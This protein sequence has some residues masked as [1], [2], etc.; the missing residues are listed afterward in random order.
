MQTE[1][2]LNLIQSM[3]KAEKRF[4]RRFADMS[5]GTQSERYLALFSAMETLEEDEPEEL[6]ALVGDASLKSNLP[7]YRNRLQSL[8]LRSL[9]TLYAG[10]SAGSEIRQLLEEIEILYER[11]LFAACGKR[12]EKALSIATSHEQESLLMEIHAWRRKLTNQLP[13]S[14]QDEALRDLR[15]DEITAVARLEKEREMAHHHERQR[16]R[17]RLRLVERG[18]EIH[19]VELPSRLPDYA[20]FLT[21]VHYHSTMAMQQLSAN[22]VA[23]ATE[24]Y[25]KAMS[26]WAADKNRILDHSDLYLQT[27]NN[28][29]GTLLVGDRNHDLFLSA[30]QHLRNLPDL[31]R[32]TR[33]S[34]QWLGYH[35]EL[36]FSMNFAGYGATQILVKEI[37]EWI[38]NNTTE[39]HVS[40]L[41]AFRFNITMFYFVYGEYSRA[42]RTLGK[43]LN[44]PGKAERRDI[45]NFARILQVLL[46]FEMQNIDL[47]EYLVRSAYRYLNRKDQL[48]EFELAVFT[49]VR[50]CGLLASESERQPAY[51]A[52]RDKLLSMQASKTTSVGH[53]EIMLWLESK[54]KGVPLR[55]LFEEKLAENQRAAKMR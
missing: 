53:G 44:Q 54:L 27:Y 21:Q 15:A 10:R 29:L 35:Q 2:L 34:F 1:G 45:R 38:A 17:A 36:I 31:P 23:E 47:N 25:T 7:V 16:V 24:T 13:L 20:N 52:L 26:L 49:M 50:Q 19:P 5:G 39:I 32:H 30:V 33:V 46:Q 14:L 41:L 42:N 6:A 51:T 18:D 12:I 28:Y 9:R 22:Q 4:F 55:Q 40:R 8:I 11:R 37:E 43:I 48:Y 3:S